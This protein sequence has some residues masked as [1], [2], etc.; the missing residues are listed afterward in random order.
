MR[1]FLEPSY[2]EE[3]LVSFIREYM[4]KNGFKKAVIALSGGIDSATTLFLTTKAIGAD[5]VVTLFLPS[6]VTSKQ[7]YK[8]TEETT[9][10]AGIKEHF[11]IPID[12]YAEPF[13]KQINKN[14]KN[15]KGILRFG[16]IMARIR[17]IITY[18]YSMIYDALVVGTENKTEALLGYSTMW[19]D[20]AAGIHPMG[21]IYKTEVFSLAK[22]LGVPESIINKPPSAELWHGQTDEDELGVRYKIADEILYYLFDKKLKK[23]EVIK[24]GYDEKSV[25]RIIELNKKSEYK[26]RFPLSCSFER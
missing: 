1:I 7:N 11:V 10:K 15:N 18:D 3:K 13:K 9:K 22:H 6:E 8:D 4:D 23:D 2:M 25:N 24:M 12:P 21:D 17:M 16:N 5:N 14:Q 19:G 20:M 26:R